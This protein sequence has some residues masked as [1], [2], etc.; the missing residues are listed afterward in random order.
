MTRRGCVVK[1]MTE[2]STNLFSPL[3]LGRYRLANRVTM[4]A[5]T[6]QRSGRLI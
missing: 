5:L 6:R 2:T 3:D 1:S 4:A